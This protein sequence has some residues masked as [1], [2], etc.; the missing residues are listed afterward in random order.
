MRRTNSWRLG[1]FALVVGSAAP[2]AGQIILPKPTIPTSPT[3]YTAPATSG[4]YRVV[5]SGFA[6]N[7]ET[8][9]RDSDGKKDEVY[10]A[11]AL[12]L[13]DR[14]DGR[15]ISLPNVVRT[16]EYGDIGGKN[17]SR[18][19]AGS[20]SRS[21]GLWS[22]NGADYAPGGLDPRATVGPTPLSDRLPLLVFEGGLSDGVEALLVAPS[23][24]E[25]DGMQAPYDNY[26]ANWKTG[27]I[28]KLIGSPAVQ[29]QLTNSSLTSAV[30]PGDN[31]LQ[32][33][34]ALANV[35]SGGIIGSYL[36][37]TTTIV[38]NHVDRPVGLAPYQNADQ[39]QDRV[40]VV[41]REKLTSL[42]V[43][44]GITIAIPFAEP[45]DGQ[46]NGIYTAYLRVE[47]VQ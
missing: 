46:L 5:I 12:V 18:I 16:R 47:R 15:M 34:S 10:A 32:V 44:S 27:G 3:I 8:V 39:Y 25:S 33:V 35:F 26:S 4:R 17:S 6:T 42:A 31:A 29:N 1:C 14:R 2:A 23:L 22:G 41:T 11:A 43:G 7:K 21:G 37:G 24:W 20:A 36:L 19:Q 13:W 9:D 38:T 30:V 45:M 40:V 28:A